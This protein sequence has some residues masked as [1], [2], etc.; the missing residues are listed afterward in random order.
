MPILESLYHRRS[1]MLRRCY[2]P[3]D[4]SFARY[5]GRGI[6]VCPEWRKSYQAFKD[7]AMT[8]GYNPSLQLDR[9]NNDGDYTP[10]NCRFITLKENIRNRVQTPRYWET[11]SKNLRTNEELRKRR[12]TA[13]LGKP[14]IRVEDGRYFES[15]TAAAKF[16]GV[17]FSALRHGLVNHGFA[18]GYHWRYAA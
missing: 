2:N 16:V 11:S 18:A 9:R 10:E 7:W 15:G 8:H 12:I 17:T 1:A 13:A 14:V 4:R 5:G 6:R 3:K